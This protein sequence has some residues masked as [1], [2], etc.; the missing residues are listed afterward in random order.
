MNNE[1][2]RRQTRSMRKAK[3]NNSGENTRRRKTS[4]NAKPSFFYDKV[5]FEAVTAFRATPADRKRIADALNNGAD[6]NEIDPRQNDELKRTV[7]SWTKDYKVSDLLIKAGADINPIDNTYQ[8]V[9]DTAFQSQFEYFLRKG[10]DINYQDVHGNTPVMRVLIN[11]VF[12]SDSDYNCCPSIDIMINNGADITIKNNEGK[13]LFDLFSS[14]GAMIVPLRYFETLFPVISTLADNGRVEIFV[15]K[16]SK[17]W[18]IDAFNTISKGFT[19]FFIQRLLLSAPYFSDKSI[20]AAFISHI[21]TINPDYFKNYFNLIRL[22]PIP[23]LIERRDIIKLML[24]HLGKE[25]T[26]KIVS[27]FLQK[28]RGKRFNRTKKLLAHYEMAINESE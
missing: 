28:T 24:K 9:L 18:L 26:Y 1:G 15:E 21:D 16:V 4:G 11:K 5:L 3:K 23:N 12:K 8:S 17:K 25:E 14:T 7:L 10:A 22:W 13:D 6:P 19:P 27:E 2:S 20:I